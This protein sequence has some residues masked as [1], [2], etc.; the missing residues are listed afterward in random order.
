MKLVQFLTA[1]ALDLKSVRNVDNLIPTL[2]S[3]YTELFAKYFAEDE[4]KKSEVKHHMTDLRKRTIKSFGFEWT[5]FSDYDARNFLNLMQ[6]EDVGFFKNRFG[7]DVGCAAGRH[8]RQAVE[9][10]AEMVA[11]DLSWLNWHSKIILQTKYI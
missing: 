3:F 4:L 11:M 9:Y 10:G 1:K 8:S 5:E 6:I 7:L 2:Q